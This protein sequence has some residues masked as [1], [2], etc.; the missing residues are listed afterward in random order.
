M[1]IGAVGC[2]STRYKMA[3]P[4]KPTD[5][6][7]VVLN[8]TVE[9]GS[10]AAVVQSVLIFQGPGSW[11]KQAYWDEYLV[12]IVNRGTTSITLEG[13]VLTGL[14]IDP[15]AAGDK[16]WVLEKASR[17]ALAYNFGLTRQVVVQ[18]G[19][20][21]GTVMAAMAVGHLIAPAGWFI[22]AGAAAGFLV[23]VPVAIGGTLYRNIS[24]RHKIEAEFTRRR[25]VLPR[26]INPGETVQG[27]LFFRITPGPRQLSLACKVDGEARTL[28]IDLS[29]L[30]GL[31]LKTAEPAPAPA[32]KP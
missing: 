7:P 17:S 16:P 27:S 5:A 18:V 15:Q 9:Q 2:M 21:L 30:A 1:A 23:G 25:L 28:A 29:P 10:V 6:G 22:S 20:G 19:G 4:P 31:H 12:A 24:G 11:K 32:M 8:L 14:P 26:T 13:A 3:A